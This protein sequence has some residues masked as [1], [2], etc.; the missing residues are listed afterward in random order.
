MNFKRFNFIVGLMLITMIVLAACGTSS[1]A[2]PADKITV[3]LSWFH[4]VEYAGFYTAV[5]KGYYAEENIE[6]I[7]NAGGPEI[8]PVNEV[9]NGNAQ[10]GITSGD[11]IIIEKSNQKNFI[12]VGTIFKENPLTI[13][14]L[15]KDNIQ[16]PNDL[17]GKTVGV[18][19]LD[20]SNFFDLPFLALLSRTGLDRDSIQYALIQDFQGANEIKAGNM[21]AMSGMFATDQQVMAMEAGDELSLIYYKDYGY[22]VYINTIFT[23]SEYAANNPDIL[24]RF[25]RATMKGYQYA[26]ENPEEAAS[27]ALKYDPALDLGYQTEVMK[28]Q[29]PF[30]DTGDGPLGSM[31]ESIWKNTQDI[32][33]EFDLISSPVDLNSIYT[34]QFVTP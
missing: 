17:V 32:L 24:T 10:L 19:S 29:I 18:Y 3:Q 1:A 7:L 6:V 31:N 2:K 5:E 16:K 15:S 25:M 21:D 23:T 27:L 11:S 26:I 33:L 12:A 22:D 4:G 8:N 34:N 13:T 20:L 30:I 14:S 9:G 28:V